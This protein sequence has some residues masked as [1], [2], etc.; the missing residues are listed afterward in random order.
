MVTE[1]WCKS[2]GVTAVVK[3]EDDGLV[4]WLGGQYVGDYVLEVCTIQQV[5]TEVVEQWSRCEM[6]Q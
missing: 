4:V 6:G 5:L 1:L 2:R 3:P